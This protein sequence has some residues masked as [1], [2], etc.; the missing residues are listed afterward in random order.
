M[1]SWWNGVHVLQDF[2]E[3]HRKCIARE[4]RLARERLLVVDLNDM[5]QDRFLDDNDACGAACRA[6][7]CKPG[8][9]S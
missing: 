5:E 4:G 9:G 8:A 3:G 6:N 7:L 2:E 1:Q